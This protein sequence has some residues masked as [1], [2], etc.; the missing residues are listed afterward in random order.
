MVP[1]RRST[2][3]STSDTQSE[4][5]PLTPAAVTFSDE[6]FERVLNALAPKPLPE[7]LK[8]IV[9]APQILTAPP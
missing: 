1:R 7:P 9:C 6:R 5:L 2:K 8:D 4:R 3:K